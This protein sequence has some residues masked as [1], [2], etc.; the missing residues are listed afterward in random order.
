MG[1]KKLEVG[2]RAADWDS[3]YVGTVVEAWDTACIVEYDAHG[4][5]LTARRREYKFYKGYA[6]A[7]PALLYQ[8][9]YN[10]VS[11]MRDGIPTCLPD[12]PLEWKERNKALK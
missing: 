2:D 8:E 6:S 11:M 4:R 12:M 7:Q 1:T 3:Y 10:A 5:Y 9:W